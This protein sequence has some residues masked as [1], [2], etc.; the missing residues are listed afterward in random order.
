MVRENPCL[1]CGACCAS[2]RVSFYWREADEAQGGLV[3]LEL[4]EDLTPL[5]R[6]MKGTN[7]KRPRCIALEGEVGVRVRC[8][9]YE[10]RPTPCRE[11]GVTWENGALRA[12]EGELARCSAAR[13]AWGLLPLG[14][15]PQE[16]AAVSIPTPSGPW[17]RV[18][19]DA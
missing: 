2:Y 14:P 5:R 3:P 8:T 11:F 16:G 18:R 6:C 9:I 17:R 10:R 19:Q 1:D 15:L 13:A 12:S 7:Q 4:T